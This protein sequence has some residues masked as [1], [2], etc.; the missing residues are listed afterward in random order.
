MYRKFLS[1]IFLFLFVFIAGCSG[2]GSNCNQT[3]G[4]SPIPTPPPEPTPRAIE[5]TFMLSIVYPDGTIIQD[6]NITISDPNILLDLQFDEQGNR[7]W[8]INPNTPDGTSFTI[9]FDKPGHR[10][11]VLTVTLDG[12][13]I[14]FEN[15]DILFPRIQTG[16]V[17]IVSD[18]SIYSTSIWRVTPAR[19]CNFAL[20][21]AAIPETPENKLKYESELFSY[22]F[23]VANT[24]YGGIGIGKLEPNGEFVIIAGTPTTTSGTFAPPGSGT[25]SDDGVGKD[26]KFVFPYCLAITPDAKTLYMSEISGP[27]YNSTKRSCSRIRKLDTMT[28]EVTTI[29]DFKALGII[30]APLQTDPNMPDGIYGLS[31]SKDGKYLYAGATT[32]ILKIPLS[33]PLN[34]TVIAGKFNDP[35]IFGSNDGSLANAKF[36]FISDIAVSSDETIIYA[37]DWTNRS[38]SASGTIR[39][40]NLADNTVTT[41]ASGFRAISDGATGPRYPTGLE[42]SKDNAKLFITSAPLAT[43]TTDRTQSTLYAMDTAT[44][45]V[46]VFSSRKGISAVTVKP[47]GNLFALEPSTPNIH[48]VL[49]LNQAG[50]PSTIIYG[51]SSYHG[52]REGYATDV[53][54]G[55]I[56]DVV[57]SNDGKSAYFFSAETSHRIMRYNTETAQLTSFSGQGTAGN[58]NSTAAASRFN[59]LFAGCIDPDGDW[60][61]V[62]E[63]NNKTV[64]RVSTATGAVSAVVSTGLDNP[65][66]ISI[67]KDGNTLFLADNNIIKTVDLTVA[68][69]TTAS[70]WKTG[71]TNLNGVL[72]SKDGNTLYAGSSGK[73]TFLNPSSGAVIKEIDGSAAGSDLPPLSSTIIDIEESIFGNY[74][75]VTDSHRVALVNLDTEAVTTMV[76]DQSAAGM[77]DAIGSAARFNNPRGIGVAKDGR[78]VYICDY[79]NVV[80]RRV[81]AEK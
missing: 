9:T 32:C 64:R 63:T 38:I 73:I 50:S 69:P 19:F 39:K 24:T 17:P 4:V 77:I 65:R 43:A 67:S 7:I 53:D 33:D 49:S 15:G 18:K 55:K 74:L 31:V 6:V 16:Y 54:S 59:G 57:I 78:I 28:K 46:S 11:E 76:G 61:Y 40:I 81:I 29:I 75:I 23:Y 2:G 5:R 71:F 21:I 26:A 72:V 13:R 66:G 60:I 62:T 58:T 1:V 25:N 70:D 42:L 47:G 51:G 12:D 41:V 48:Y 14:V 44:Y 80:I 8:K 20:S 52:F 22:G 36:S 10:F 68:L 35:G 45:A 56:S 34:Y 30:P 79:D 3:Y 27:T 37:Y